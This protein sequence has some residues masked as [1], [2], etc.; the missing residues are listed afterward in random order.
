MRRLLNTQGQ[1][2]NL[3]GGSVQGNW[4]L[5]QRSVVSSQARQGS[6]RAGFGLEVNGRCGWTEDSR[7]TTHSTDRGTTRSAARTMIFSAAHR[8]S[9]IGRFRG[10]EFGDL[11]TLVT[12]PVVGIG[13]KPRPVFL[14]PGDKMR[15]SIEGRAVQEQTVYAWDPARLDG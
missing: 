2:R 12:P 14:N 6:G 8:L 15:P 5:A 4:A 3:S 13:G 9:Y 11:I 7:R 1:A 10:P